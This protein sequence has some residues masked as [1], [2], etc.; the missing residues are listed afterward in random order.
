MNAIT[1]MQAPGKYQF[2]FRDRK[3]KMKLIQDYRHSSIVALV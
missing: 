2:L 3:K 1:P